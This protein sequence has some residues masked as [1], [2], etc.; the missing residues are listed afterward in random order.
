MP[1]TKFH[2]R[3]IEPLSPEAVD[4]DDRLTQ[5][6]HDR[7]Q[8]MTWAAIAERY[9]YSQ[10]GAAQTAVSRY[11]EKV[12]T[13][14]TDEYREVITERL[15][16]LFM[17]YWPAATGGNIAAAYL[18]NTILGH[19]AKLNGVGIV[20]VEQH[21][22]QTNQTLIIIPDKGQLPTGIADIIEGASESD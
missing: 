21:N 18:I 17:S 1:D 19:M 12:K 3:E 15:E 6:I 4:Y 22:Q 20:K 16:I 10:A 8:G 14:R 11:L 9:G 2:T 5:M 7:A 13:S